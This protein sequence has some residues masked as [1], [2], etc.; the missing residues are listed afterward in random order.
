MRRALAGLILFSVF[1]SLG[2]SQEE[3]Y[4]DGGAYGY[5][6]IDYDPD[7][8]Q[9]TAYSETDL[10][11]DLETYYAPTLTLAV[12][13]QNNHFITGSY[14]NGCTSHYDGATYSWSC[15][16][17]A[18][19]GATYT[20]YGGHGGELLQQYACQDPPY[21]GNSQYIDYLN[22]SALYEFGLLDLGA[23]DFFGPGPSTPIDSPDVTIGETFD[24]ASVSIPAACNDVRDLLIR[25]YMTLSV[26]KKVQCA[27]FVPEGTWDYYYSYLTHSYFNYAD[28]TMDQ[29]TGA[30]IYAVLQPYAYV[31]GLNAIGNQVV[32][33]NAPYG[34]TSG[35]RNPMANIVAANN[36][37]THPDP[38]SRH[39]AGDGAD[40][41]T[42]WSGVSIFLTV[43]DAAAAANSGACFENQAQ[44]GYTH[45]HV[46]WR[47]KTGPANNWGGTDD[48]PNPTTAKP[49]GCPT[50]WAYH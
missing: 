31:T 29:S 44:E 3:I 45:V 47:T 2:F 4:N 48:W 9:V 38:T 41:K 46:D 22:F 34:L 18:A 10:D 30:G 42:N 40:L 36:N 11:V 13:D 1:G 7:S 27:D 5:T 6:T 14:Q 20:A 33:Q 16:F 23:A 19:S 35:Y 8:G 39:Q 21:C 26:Y 15:Q 32:A 43:Y 25:E 17:A 49:N 24:N 50:G 12:Y 28:L 37:H